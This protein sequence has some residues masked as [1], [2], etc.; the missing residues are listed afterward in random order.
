MPE[1][2]SYLSNPG[3]SGSYIYTP[4][5]RSGVVA[6]LVGVD[7]GLVTVV[8]AVSVTS[9]PAPP[10]G[11]NSFALSTSTDLGAAALALASAIIASGPFA[12]GG[13]LPDPLVPLLAGGLDGIHGFSP[14][15]GPL[16]AIWSMRPRS[17]LETSSPMPPN[18]SNGSSAVIAFGPTCPGTTSTRFVSV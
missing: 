9:S 16:P 6:E 1:L 4:G 13:V 15:S 5:G 11:S 14:F 8:G 3:V 7:G 18:A 17:A 2:K 12:F 10:N